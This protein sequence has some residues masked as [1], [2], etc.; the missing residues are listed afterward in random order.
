MPCLKPRQTSRK[1]R[2]RAKC[3]RF[4][5][6]EKCYTPH[7]PALTHP[8]IVDCLAAQH[9]LTTLLAISR[10][11]AHPA[12]ISLYNSRYHFPQLHLHFYL[13]FR[14]SHRA[15]RADSAV[16]RTMHFRN[17]VLDGN[18]LGVIDPIGSAFTSGSR[19]FS[20]LT[21]AAVVE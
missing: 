18:E 7:A 16:S 10:L 12:L 17:A 5:E 4:V 11:F 20:V 21:A 9:T 8:R 14:S 2:A 6:R 1:I 3:A 15:V 13:P 19:S